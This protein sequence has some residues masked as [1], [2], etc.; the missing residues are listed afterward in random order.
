V[1]AEAAVELAL[2]EQGVA[3]TGSGE[4]DEARPQFPSNLGVLLPGGALVV[5]I[6]E[7]DGGAKQTLQAICKVR[8]CIY[9]FH[10]RADVRR[11]RS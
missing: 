2:G 3:F 11:S 9:S 5:K 7:G 4:T 10:A 1:L 6:L 8:I